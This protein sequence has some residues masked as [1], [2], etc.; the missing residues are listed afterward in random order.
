MSCQARSLCA[1]VQGCGVVHVTRALEYELA[2]HARVSLSA[3]VFCVCARGCP[4]RKAVA[5]LAYKRVIFVER[6]LC[7]LQCW[8]L[9]GFSL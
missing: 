6:I 9:E 3:C 1:G 4:F 8:S 5:P 2:V 7:R